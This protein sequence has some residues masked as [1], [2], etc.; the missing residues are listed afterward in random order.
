M[1]TIS[2]AYSCGSA[3]TAS[4]GT[5]LGVTYNLTRQGD[6]L[7]V[8]VSCSIAGD[9]TGVTD[10]FGNLYTLISSKTNGLY[11]LYVFL[12]PSNNQDGFFVNNTIT[13]TFSTTALTASIQANGYAMGAGT[14]TGWMVQDSHNEATGTAN[15][16]VNLTTVAKATMLIGAAIG[17]NTSAPTAGSGF[18]LRS[19]GTAT[20]LSYG[21]EDKSESSQGTYAVAMTGAGLT[22][23]TICANA[24]TIPST[25]QAVQSANS[26]FNGGG[27]TTSLPLAYPSA[28]TAGNVN[29]VFVSWTDGTTVINTP[30]DTSGNVYTLVGHI[31][32]VTHNGSIYLYVC[33][34]IAAAGA[35][36]N[37]VTFTWAS[38]ASF[39]QSTIIELT[40]CKV[41]PATVATAGGSGSSSSV[42][43]VTTGFPGEMMFSYVMTGDTAAA[44]SGWAA[45]IS[46]GSQQA[47]TTDYGY[48]TQYQYVPASGTSVTPT[49]TFGGSGDWDMISFGVYIPGASTLNALFFGSD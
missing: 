3:S 9:V 30:T 5:T 8:Q 22:T 21:E 25:P 34:S 11:N 48:M 15:P 16:T 1:P 10:T 14:G 43:P 38:A 27:S 40:P 42:G 19:S 31:Q 12:C 32:D 2:F 28:Q 23:S 35:G 41:D 49:N 37:T 7:I 39:A 24:L 36:A 4:S 17:N 18:N 33:N 47:G 20:A 13:A 26:G 6:A 44:G 46:S 29:I 45:L